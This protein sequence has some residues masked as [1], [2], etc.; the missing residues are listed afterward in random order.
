MQR[1]AQPCWRAS[2]LIIAQSL[3]Q[4]ARQHIKRRAAVRRSSRTCTLLP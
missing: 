4:N 3:L 1:A 2:N